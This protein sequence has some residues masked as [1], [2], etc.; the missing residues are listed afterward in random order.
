MAEYSV[1]PACFSA[2]TIARDAER[3]RVQQQRFEPRCVEKCDDEAFSSCHDAQIAVAVTEVD[4]RRL[5][6]RAR[7][8]EQHSAHAETGQ[9]VD[10]EGR[11]LAWGAD[12]R[13]GHWRR[14]GTLTKQADRF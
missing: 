13:H 7:R 9:V 10:V 4:A 3:T 11:A 1:A 5:D 14:A 12:H 8:V 6:G 2:Q